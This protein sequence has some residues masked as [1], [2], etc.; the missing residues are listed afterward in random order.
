MAKLQALVL[1][2][3]RLGRSMQHRKLLTPVQPTVF[4]IFT[5]PTVP[6]K[7]GGAPSRL[8]SGGGA[9]SHLNTAISSRQTRRRVRTGA[10]ME[11]FLLLSAKPSHPAR[12]DVIDHRMCECNSQYGVVLRSKL[13]QSERS[14]PIYCVSGYTTTENSIVLVPSILEANRE[15][16]TS[17]VE[18]KVCAAATTYY[19]RLFC[20]LIHR[21]LVLSCSKGGYR[22]LHSGRY[23]SEAAATTSWWYL[24]KFSDVVM[25]P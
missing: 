21:A 15:F 13:Q 22:Q 19:S 23:D 7:D 25:V 3:A 17:T 10:K 12:A 9:P 6:I 14:E 8:M 18:G 24:I 16:C 11:G 1:S 20:P 2:I 5:S 4:N